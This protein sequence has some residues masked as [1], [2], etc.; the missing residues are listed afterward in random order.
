MSKFNE[1]AAKRIIESYQ[2]LDRD[3]QNEVIDKIRYDSVL[4]AAHEVEKTKTVQFGELY[5]QSIENQKNF[6]KFE[7]I[8]SGLAYFDDATLGFR[9]GEMT[10][11]AGPS[12][13]GKTMVALNLVTNLIVNSGVKVLVISM[14]MTAQEINDRVYNMTNEHNNLMENLIIQTELAVSSKHIDIM[15]KRIKPDI[16]MVDHVQFLANQNQGSEYERITKATADMKRIAINRNIPVILISH[17]A[18]TRS[19]KLGQATASDLKGASNIE[20]DCDMGFMINKEQIDSNELV[21]TLFKHRTRRP[22]LFHKDCIIS[23]NGIRIAD[24]G[25][26]RDLETPQQVSSMKNVVEKMW[27]N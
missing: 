18:K 19:G 1:R 24:H 12:N 7:G 25:Y 2:E 8:G 21:I 4:A 5:A 15:V 23:F 27:N 11:I 10:V 26:Y 17:V 3:T 16:L 6:N 9:G 14:E 13:F 20:Q 22:K